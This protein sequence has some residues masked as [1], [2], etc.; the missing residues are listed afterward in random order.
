VQTCTDEGV[1]F[2]SNSTNGRR[3]SPERVI[4]AGIS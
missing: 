4:I 1:L 2:Y 3:F